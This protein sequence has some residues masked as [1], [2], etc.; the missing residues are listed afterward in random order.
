MCRNSCGVASTPDVLHA[1]AQTSR[2][3][4]TPSPTT[5]SSPCRPP[6]PSSRS[7]SH[8]SLPIEVR[9]GAARTGALDGRDLKAVAVYTTGALRLGDGIPVFRAQLVRLFGPAASEPTATHIVDW[10]RERFT[11]AQ[12]L[13]PADLDSHVRRTRVPASPPWRHPLGFHPDGNCHP[14][15]IE[16]ALHVGVAA[17][18]RIEEARHDRERP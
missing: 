11:A 15:H 14:G 12:R 5:W 17:A 4:A 3:V 16:G 10:S 9:A 1:R 6:R 8:P 13:C 18:R 2:G 7:P